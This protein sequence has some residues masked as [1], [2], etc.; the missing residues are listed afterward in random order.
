MGISITE[1]C[2][3]ECGVTYW[4]TGH[5]NKELLKTRNAFYCPNGHKQ[6]YAGETEEQK[7]IIWRDRYKRWYENQ[8]DT[9]ERL[10]RSNAA[11]RGVITRNKNREDLK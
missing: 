9:S 6:S 11:L 10:A 8:K 7:A 4:I 1:I 5:F 2:C 3:C